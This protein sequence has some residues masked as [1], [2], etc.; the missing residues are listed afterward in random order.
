MK[1]NWL[2]WLSLAVMMGLLVAAC[3]TATPTDEPAPQPPPDEPAPP[4]PEG[5][6]IDC[7]GASSGDEVSVMYQWSGAEEEKINAILAP[8]AEECGVSIVSESTR[9]DAVLDT[10][11][12]SSPP[13][14]LFWPSAAP[15]VLYTDQLQ[16]LGSVGAHAENY[17]DFWIEQ[18]TVGGRWLT[19]PAKADIK[20][21]VW[22]SPV[23]FETF[24]YAIPTTFEELDALVEQ[25]VADGNTAWSMGMESGAATGWTGSDF[26]QDVL[27]T[28]QGPEYV[29]GLIDG[30]ISYDDA[31][32]QQAYETYAKWASD[33]TYTVGGSTGT[34]NT[35]FL[36][37]IYK[38]F[39]DPPEAMMVKQSGF[40]GGEVVA[41]FPA[42]E[43]G[44]DFDFFAFPGAQGMQGG[45]DLM[46]AFGDSPAAQALVGYLTSD[47][48]GKAWAEAG[49]DLSPNS[50]AAGNYTDVQLAKKG[51][52]LAGATGFT[53]DLGDALGSPFNA[54]EWKAIIEVVQGGDAKSA[55]SAAAASQRS[56]LALAPSVDCM[57]A[58][59]ST[60]SVM[61]QWSGA[62][63]EK[64]NTVLAP[65]VE[66]CDVE[67]VSET[68]RDAAVL[69]TRV[70]SDPPDVLFWPD[71]SPVALYLDQL[72][73]LGSVGA[74][75]DNYADF[76]VEQGTVDGRWVSLP[77][78]ADIKT[79]VWY[80]PIGF[81]TFGYS[82]PTSFADL[83]AL[84]EQMVAD[85]NTPW[86]MGMESG[87]ATGWTGSDFIQDVL[88]AQQGPEYVMSLIDGSTSYDDAG[89][90]QAYET[91][92]K[93]ASD[94][95]YTIG[96]ATGTV[97]IGFLDAIHRTFADPQ[98]AMMVKQSGFA[99]GEVVAQFPS[100]EYGT[101]FDFFA[102][103]GAQGMQ[104]GADNLFV[105]GDSAA[106]QAMVA[107][108]TS[109]EGA[110]SWAKAGFD[111]SP[112]K[113]AEGQYA[114]EQL[115]KKGAAL[116]G[117]TGFTPDL[118]DALGAPFNA[119]E[120]TAIIAVVQGGDAAAALAEAA[121]AQAESLQ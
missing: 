106:T 85:G 110:A 99:G 44:V 63:E 79:I 14:V 31:G 42:L 86:S 88:L 102:F 103:P 115:A 100:L 101:D 107:F 16:D 51:D 27:L 75:A 119:A 49:F 3:G 23:Q 92:A 52:A 116:G 89:V 118:G 72:Q 54:A 98:E 104:G 43:Y 2:K 36:D 62:E 21:I 57:G 78:K 11:V 35:G 50:G 24:G 67:L 48:G 73:D 53:P 95:T 20:T 90:I 91:Y 65:F 59:G 22:Y 18:G 34:V 19:L 108:L 15:A 94:E 39:S 6:M 97:E 82:V 25:M 47:E 55:L 112:N 13:D 9:D 8:F 46:M 76:W 58:E 105:F 84:V 40:A 121:A 33:D 28:Q 117:A 7:M 32:V 81:E 69:D 29:M 17:A 56:S 87:A 37:A 114:D 1:S 60:V 83:D 26:I 10:R 70:K 66:A 111:L 12:Q 80:S 77:V 41:Q 64:I 68:T 45:A 93:W 38:A 109:A 96:G 71:V 113:W 4:P 74:N 61:W 5:A 120:W 30:S